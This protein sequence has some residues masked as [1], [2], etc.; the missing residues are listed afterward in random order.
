MAKIL[1]GVVAAI[2]QLP[3]DNV[4]LEVRFRNLNKDT[5]N[6]RLF[7]RAKA[8]YGQLPS[9]KTPAI[10]TSI[11]EYF[12]DVRYTG[13]TK[14]TK[15]E[16]VRPIY[17]TE[18]PFLMKISVQLEV[19]EKDD[20]PETRPTLIRHKSRT[21]IFPSQYVRADFTVVREAADNCNSEMVDQFEIELEV[22]PGGPITI[23]MVDALEEETKRM[24]M[25]LGETKLLYTQAER[26]NAIRMYNQALGDPN[27]VL[28]TRNGL[29]FARNLRFD[30]CVYGGLI[31]NKN[32]EYYITHKA[33]GV[34]K[35]AM[36]GSIGTWLI[37]PTDSMSLIRR[38][39]TKTLIIMDGELING[40]TYVPFD[41]LHLGTTPLSGLSDRLKRLTA[42]KSPGDDFTIIHKTFHPIRQTPSS[43]QSAVVTVMDEKPDFPTDGWI[44]MPE[45]DGV[46][47]CPKP[48]L[49]KCPDTCK[50]KPFD[51]LTIDFK[52]YQGQL[53]VGAPNPV[54][55]RYDLIPF[56]G[57]KFDFS[58]DQVDLRGLQ[59]GIPQPNEFAG[60]AFGDVEKTELVGEVGGELVQ[61]KSDGGSFRG[62]GRGRGGKG[63]KRRS[64]RSSIPAT[65][66][67]TPVIELGPYVV[68]NQIRLKLVRPRPDK[69]NPNT[70]EDAQTVWSDIN[71]PLRVE[72]LAGRT[73]DFAIQYHS[74]LKQALLGT[75]PSTACVIDIGAGRGGDLL[76]LKHVSKILA[77]EPT[78]GDEYVKRA[79]RFRLTD[80]IRL[81]RVKG[82]E[83]D[84]IADSA[85][86]FFGADAKVYVVMM[87]S[88]SFFFED[89]AVAL[90]KTFARLAQ[91]F[92]DINFVYLTIEGS[93]VLKL[94]K[95]PRTMRLNNATLTLR[96][97]MKTLEIDIPNSIVDH[98]VEWLVDLNLLN[99]TNPQM[100]PANK[101]NLEFRRPIL[102]KTEEAYNELFVYG[103]GVITRH[104]ERFNVPP[105]NSLY[106]SI[107][108]MGHPDY[109]LATDTEKD[110]LAEQLRLAHAAVIRRA[111]R[112]VKE[113][114]EGKNEPTTQDQNLP[115]NIIVYAPTLR[116]EIQRIPSS[117]KHAATVKL[118]YDQQYY[119]LGIRLPDGTI[120]WKNA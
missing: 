81:L 120:Q 104:L 72:A 88:L 103:T 51:K 54:T 67:N 26:V 49:T 98:Q 90:N 24:L 71:R 111:R 105:E 40:T 84:V 102:S 33:D 31:G 63:Y 93:Q 7:N 58:M 100:F 77:I 83:A 48:D 118:V 112:K 43:L 2:P 70:L 56:V 46:K 106:H 97:D 16:L 53:Y 78:Y 28:L 3:K 29:S 30:D 21:S 66:M 59:T 19:E 69:Y 73:L 37:Y 27:N 117:I 68:N 96:P 119:P 35:I 38:S 44:I 17:N 14:I 95:Q 32:T 80:K 61:M 10:S 92:G 12:G 25:V 107:V 115:V 62:R 110:I 6:A 79:T 11:D 34:R 18:Y 22:T 89:D 101:P 82:Q 108:M 65:L 116:S 47:K 109:A 60:G 86:E 41:L 75:I 8:T 64:P 99:I 50:V 13:D 42:I 39:G 9:V 94:F 1:E 85:V 20:K 74:K 91:M 4:E 55:H 114:K 23:D 5:I 57:G 76:K 113:G 36:I 87:L 45:H 15:R 52:Y